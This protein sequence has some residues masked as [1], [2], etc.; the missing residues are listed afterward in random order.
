MHLLTLG[1]DGTILVPFVGLSDAFIDSRVPHCTTFDAICG[2][3]GLCVGCEV[4]IG[5]P[6]GVYGAELPPQRVPFVGS[7][8]AFDGCRS[9]IYKFVG[10]FGV[11]CGAKWQVPSYIRG[12]VGSIWQLRSAKWYQFVDF[13]VRHL[14]IVVYT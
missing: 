9:S 13:S 14:F 1:P 7:L 4:P 8:G 5:T 11:V 3:V 6:F 2:S 12:P 10:V